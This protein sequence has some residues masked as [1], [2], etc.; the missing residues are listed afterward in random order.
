[1]RPAC[2]MRLVNFFSALEFRWL[3]VYNPL[4]KFFVKGT[5]KVKCHFKENLDLL[6]LNMKLRKKTFLQPLVILT[7]LQRNF[8][9]N[10]NPSIP[11]FLKIFMY[12]WNEL[13]FPRT[14]KT[15]ENGL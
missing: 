9:K 7:N 4:I 11:G 14:F 1:M 10:L 15:I 6:S 12:Y 8:S 2:H 3:E 13:G 5:K